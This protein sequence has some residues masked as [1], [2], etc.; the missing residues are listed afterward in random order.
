M[1]VASVE[2][3]ENLVVAS[4]EFAENLVASCHQRCQAIIDNAGDWREN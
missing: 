2:F 1:E 3:A 4:V